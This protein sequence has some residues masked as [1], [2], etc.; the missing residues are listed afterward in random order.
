MKKSFDTCIGATAIFQKCFN[1]DDFENVE[2]IREKSDSRGMIANYMQAD[3]ACG[4][5]Y[6]VVTKKLDCVFKYGSHCDDSHDSCSNAT[7][8]FINCVGPEVTNGCGKAAGCAAK[9]YLSLQRCYFSNCDFCQT[10][11]YNNNP[12]NNLCS[13]KDA[14]SNYANTT[15]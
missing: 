8:S 15:A 13:D 7:N 4:S 9:Q 1:I 12:I 6:E 5:A 3:L 2:F 10:L 14:G 11:N